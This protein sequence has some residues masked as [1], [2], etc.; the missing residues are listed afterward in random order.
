MKRLIGS[1]VMSSLLLMGCS[2]HSYVVN[3]DGSSSNVAVGWSKETKTSKGSKTP[4]V[5]V[6]LP[7]MVGETALN[8]AVPNATAFRMSGDY[9]NNV[10]VTLSPDGN[11]LYFPD[12]T[13]ITADSEPVSLGEG[14]WLNNQGL[15]PNSVF[16]KYTFAEYA[17]LPSVPTP[18]QLKAAIIPEA[19]VIGF[20]ELPMKIGDANRNLE[21]AKQYVKEF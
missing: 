12:P 3:S 8:S 11:L 17:S 5:R 9:A 15:G 14:W 16:T 13:D 18:E 21:A 10:A 1:A 19:R 7:E 4:Q 6:K 20:I 2:H